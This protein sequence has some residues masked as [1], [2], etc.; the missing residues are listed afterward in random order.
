[1]PQAKRDTVVLIIKPLGMI[2]IE[3]S[4]K[5]QYSKDHKGADDKDN[6]RNNINDIIVRESM[7]R[8]SKK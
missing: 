8:E 6:I 7:Y 5:K 1:M 3:T 2:T 4:K